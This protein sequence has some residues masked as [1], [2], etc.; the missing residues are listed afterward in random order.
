MLL[1]NTGANGDRANRHT[2]TLA[3]QQ[4]LGNLYKNCVNNLLPRSAY[5]FVKLDEMRAVVSFSLIRQFL[6]HC[7]L[8]SDIFKYTFVFN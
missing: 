8:S 6:R 1:F 5:D 4:V 2:A 7:S 3:L